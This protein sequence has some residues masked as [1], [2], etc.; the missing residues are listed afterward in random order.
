MSDAHD[1]DA[2]HEGPIKKVKQ[3][4]VA[5]IASFLVPIFV[6][7]LLVK[8]VTA[9]LQPAA[10]SS[11]KTE[12]S[13][14]QRIQPVGRVEVEDASDASS[15]KSGEQVYA[16]QCVACHASGVANAPKLGDMAAWAPRL[17]TGYAAL[18][19]AV[20]KGK[21]AMAPQG[22]GDFNDTE[23]ARAVVYLANQSGAK[24]DEPKAP[25]AK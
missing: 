5:V 7:V 14:A 12:E 15:L 25:A 3:L 2:P 10:G 16:A 19:T 9:D 11:A 4:I 21:G 8:Y 24:F 20:M 17:K 13:V 22:G 23:I 1:K 18:L 6:I